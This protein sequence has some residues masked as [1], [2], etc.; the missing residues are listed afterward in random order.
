MKREEWLRLQRLYNMVQ[1]DKLRADVR[2]DQGWKPI[3]IFECRD[4]NDETT[5]RVQCATV[6]LNDQRLNALHPENEKQYH[7]AE[8]LC[9][10]VNSLPEIIADYMKRDTDRE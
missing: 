9:A 10:A 4:E 8:L 7:L 6:Y 3:A 1:P 5:L 2:H